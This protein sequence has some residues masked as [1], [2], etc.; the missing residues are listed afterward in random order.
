[1]FSVSPIVMDIMFN[2]SSGG[3]IKQWS[4]GNASFYID[5]RNMLPGAIVFV[6]VCVCFLFRLFYFVVCQLF[7]QVILPFCLALLLVLAGDELLT[8][9]CFFK[10]TFLPKI[11]Q[12]IRMGSGISA[13]SRLILGFQWSNILTNQATLAW[14]ELHESLHRRNNIPVRTVRYSLVKS[15]SFS[16]GEV[17][18]GERGYSTQKIDHFYSRIFTVSGIKALESLALSFYHKGIYRITVAKSMDRACTGMVTGEG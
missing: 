8:F 9:N 6:S 1:M 12:L 10:L 15:W 14:N 4:S 11:P 7:G 18:R 13:L 5:I 3:M 16:F 17:S 2:G